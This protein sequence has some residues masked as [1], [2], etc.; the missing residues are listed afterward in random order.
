MYHCCVYLHV[1]ITCDVE[2]LLYVFPYHLE[3]VS[4]QTFPSLNCCLFLRELLGTGEARSGLAARE[5]GFGGPRFS[6]QGT[7]TFRRTGPGCAGKSCTQFTY[8]S[9]S[10]ISSFADETAEAQRD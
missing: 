9:T 5:G 1:F 7:M 8:L 3:E 4:V 6:G 10:L 2:H